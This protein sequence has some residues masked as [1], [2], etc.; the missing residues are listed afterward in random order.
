MLTKRVQLKLRTTQQA[1]ERKMIDVTLRDKKRAEW[2]RE[3]TG[4][5][6]I[7]VEIKKKEWTWAGHVAR[8]QDNRWPLKGH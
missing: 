3:Q 1:M 7:I 5:K 2:V 6:D 4:V 8:K